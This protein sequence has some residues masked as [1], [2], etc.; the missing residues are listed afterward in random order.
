MKT[1]VQTGR[2]LSLAAPY[3]V[4]SGAGFKVGAIFAVAMCDAL[5]AAAVEGMLEGVF[6]LAKTSA[7][8]WTIG[9]KVY[10]DDSNKRCDTDGTVGQLI[11]A[12]T[13]VAANPSATGNVRLNG[14]APGALEGAQAAVADVATTNAIDLPTSEA[15]A[16]QLKTSL[17]A[18]LAELRIAGIILP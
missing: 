8:A 9:Q 5:S 7:Q 13:A 4:L 16:N 2:T 1:F 15:L 12:A 3:D 14:N 10:W 11:G 17:N 18:L 6:T